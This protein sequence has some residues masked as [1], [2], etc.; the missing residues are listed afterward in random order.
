MTRVDPRGLESLGR[1]LGRPGPVTQDELAG[2]ADAWRTW[3][4]VAVRAAGGMVHDTALR[5]T[6][7]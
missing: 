6:P 7:R 3:A 2:I 1:L 4:T 5:N